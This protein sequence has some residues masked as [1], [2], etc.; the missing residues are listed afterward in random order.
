MKIKRRS[1]MLFENMH[2]DDTSISLE[3]I[4]HQKDDRVVSELIPLFKEILATTGEAI[5][6]DPQVTSSTVFKKKMETF[7]KINGI[8]TKRFG[9]ELKFKY[10]IMNGVAHA[11][12]PLMLGNTSLNVKMINP[13]IDEKL[14]TMFSEDNIKELKS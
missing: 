14:Y 2:P 4:D 8:L 10:G 6:L 1:D 5:K 13:G 3:N 9:N 12:V 11:V 7:E